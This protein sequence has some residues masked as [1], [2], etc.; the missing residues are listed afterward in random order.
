MPTATCQPHSTHFSPTHS[1][2]SDQQ[3]RCKT[4]PVLYH[5]VW[6]ACPWRSGGGYVP[7]QTHARTSALAV[8][9]L[10]LWYTWRRCNRMELSL[11]TTT[12]VV[13]RASVVR[14]GSHRP[15]N[16]RGVI[17]PDFPEISGRHW[18][19]VP[20]SRWWS[21]MQL[22]SCCRVYG[23]AGAKRKKQK[24]RSQRPGDGS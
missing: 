13:H 16:G 15:I 18:P 9:P 12:R 19:T 5:G 2:P 21:G 3:T 23:R 24:L 10:Y 1:V 6:G 4:R 7:C 8:G 17:R 14:N 11:L 22:C 20:F